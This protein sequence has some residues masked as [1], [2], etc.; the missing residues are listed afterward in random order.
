MVSCLFTFTDGT[1]PLRATYRLLH[2]LHVSH[3]PVQSS[4]AFIL[5][6]F[7][8]LDV[9]ENCLSN[10][11]WDIEIIDSSAIHL[12]PGAMLLLC[13]LGNTPLVRRKRERETTSQGFCLP[14]IYKWRRAVC[15][16]CMQMRTAFFPA[17]FPPFSL[18]FWARNKK[19]KVGVGL[20]KTSHPCTLIIQGCCIRKVLRQLHSR[21]T[22]GEI[23]I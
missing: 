15:I 7:Y 21:D 12:I 14:S 23:G 11:P 16:G 1:Q 13:V 5:G 3:I 4:L 10:V 20:I 19:K 6:K 8:R 17:I 2:E 9:Y 22:A 18:F